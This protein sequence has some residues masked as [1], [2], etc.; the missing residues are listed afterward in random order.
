MAEQPFFDLILEAL[1]VFGAGAVPGIEVYIAVPLGVIMGNSPLV[2]ALV[3]VV[4][5][6]ASV[7]ALVAAWPRLKNW[8]T[9]KFLPKQAIETTGELTDQRRFLLCDRHG[10]LIIV[11]V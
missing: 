2:A 4:G 5:N 6:V 11:S 10:V 8:F 9:R 7:S 1:V 3:A